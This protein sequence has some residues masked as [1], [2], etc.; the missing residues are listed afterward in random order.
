[1]DYAITVNVWSRGNSDKGDEAAHW[2]IT[3]HERTAKTGQRY[4]LKYDERVGYYY[5]R[6]D[7]RHV[8]SETSWGRCEVAKVTKSQSRMAGEVLHQY[9]NQAGNIPREGDGKNC[10][11]FVVGLLSA[12]EAECL[13]D[14]GW[15]TFWDTQRGKPSEAVGT[16]LQQ[17][18]KSWVPAPQRPAREADARHGA[19]G[20]RKT[21][22]QLDLSKFAGLGQSIGESSKRR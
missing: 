6:M 20:P 22:R 1:M 4:D 21:T 2:G 8:E 13:I 10:Q 5:A 3:I 12:L 14:R 15:A 7:G 9:G 17:A 16:A 18:G 11:D 19:M